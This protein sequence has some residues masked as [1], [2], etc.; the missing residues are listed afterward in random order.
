VHK[1][2][3]D[4]DDIEIVM[5]DEVKDVVEKSVKLE[6]SLQLTQ[7]TETTIMPIGVENES[8]VHDLVEYMKEIVTKP[9]PQQENKK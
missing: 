5:E 7:N 2:T 3:D 1:S 9:R 4:Y 6:D 8:E